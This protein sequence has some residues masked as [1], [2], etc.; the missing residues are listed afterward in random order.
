DLGAFLLT[1]HDHAGRQVGDADRG[2]GGVHALAALTGGTVN[3]HTDILLVDLDI[4]DLVRLWVDQ[5]TGGG[6]LHAP[7]GLGHRHALHSVDAA[8]QLEVGP[9]SVAGGLL[10]AVGHG[11]VLDPAQ[12]GLVE[13]QD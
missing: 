4:L 5:H 10:G 8:L 7:L 6:G 13:A 12:V 2:V 3:I 11:H 1:G 9:C